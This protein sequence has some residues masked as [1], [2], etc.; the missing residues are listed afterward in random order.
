[1]KKIVGPF[2]KSIYCTQKKTYDKIQHLTAQIK[3]HHIE[4]IQA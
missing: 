4:Y 3:A 1:M 2:T